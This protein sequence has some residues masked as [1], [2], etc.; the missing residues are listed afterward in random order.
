MATGAGQPSDKRAQRIRVVLA[1]AVGLFTARQVT[2]KRVAEDALRKE[3]RPVSDAN[4]RVFH[5]N[6]NS[7]RCHDLQ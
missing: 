2:Y 4:G 1:A 3:K 5:K 7:P 6:K